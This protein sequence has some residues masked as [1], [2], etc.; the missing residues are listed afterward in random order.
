[1]AAST[2]P[3]QLDGASREGV[4]LVAPELPADVAVDVLGVEL[5]RAEDDLGGLHDVV[6][7][8]VSRQPGDAVVGHDLSLLVSPF[9]P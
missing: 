8:A 3:Q 7:D 4:A 6:A 5:D 9:G 2:F 1:M